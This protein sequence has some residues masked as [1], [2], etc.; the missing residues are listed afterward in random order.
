[1]KRSYFFFPLILLFTL[2]CG[3]A[4]EDIDETPKVTITSI[5][6]SASMLE[7]EVGETVNFTITGNEG[8]DLTQKAEIFINGLKTVNKTFTPTEKGDVTVSAS[9]NSISS[10]SLIIKVLPKPVTSIKVV[11]N[12]KWVD[13]NH[14]FTFNVFDSNNIDVTNQAKIFVDNS[15]IE[16]N[17][18]QPNTYGAYGIIAKFENFTSDAILVEAKQY[19]TS[20]TTKVLIEDFTGTWCGWCPRVSYGIELVEKQ[21]DN[22][23]ITAIHRGQGNDPYHF[24][25]ANI[26]NLDEGYYPNAKLNRKTTWNS[27]EPSNVNQVI[28]LT[29]INTDLGLGIDS[30]IIEN[31]IDLEISIGFLK[32]FE[33][34]KFV[35]YLLEDNLIY[36][37]ANYTEYYN[38]TSIL[39]NFEHNNVLRKVITN[40]FGD[41][42]PS[43]YMVT[44]GVFKKSFDIVIPNS[45]KNND[46]LKIVA[47]VLDAN[48]K[49]INAQKAAINTYK[50]FD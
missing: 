2:S 37:Q 30:K 28:D 35:V 27:P 40:L 38:G 31:N 22:V 47:F 44:N 32:S 46:A 17:T 11:S 19:A 7:I 29:N 18:F 34:L 41:V 21:T 15:E 33:N 16:G 4:K 23:V 8:T 24:D 1:M 49:V 13:L 26:G 20:F 3:G 50:N 45:I 42:I 48:G 14:E 9:Y 5:K 25:E 43:E 6:L 36:N 12:N 10:N 39:L